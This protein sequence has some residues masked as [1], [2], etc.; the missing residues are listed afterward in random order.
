MEQDV[1]QEKDSMQMKSGIT[2]KFNPHYYTYGYMHV[3]KEF[4]KHL[5][6]EV[7]TEDGENSR[8]KRNVVQPTLMFAT[9]PR[10]VSQ[11]Y[12]PSNGVYYPSAVSS[13]ISSVSLKTPKVKVC[14]DCKS[15]QT[16]RYHPTVAKV[17]RTVVKLPEPVV[18]NTI[19]GE[20]AVITSD[21][22]EEEPE[23]EAVPEDAAEEA[24]AESTPEAE[25]VPEEE[26]VSNDVAASTAE[27]S[28]SQVKP[29]AVQRPI[30]Y[31]AQG[32][33]QSDVANFRPAVHPHWG[34]RMTFVPGTQFYPVASQF[35]PVS[36]G[37]TT[38]VKTNVKPKLSSPLKE[39]STFPV[40]EK[41]LNLA[42]IVA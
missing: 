17:T 38:K 10:A 36:A 6:K 22:S 11:S 14:K 23:P 8:K 9:Y 34:T 3:P 30:Y 7:K 1:K 18:D 12:Y 28:T 37:V 19:Q 13:R 2:P 27:K 24:D 16:L 31:P 20:E 4:Q 26:P 15:G 25:A 21:N 39:Y 35:Y 41:D 40:N 5:E 42:A 29:V 33:L 32:V